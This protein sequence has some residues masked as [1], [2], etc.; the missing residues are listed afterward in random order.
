MYM[1]I[2]DDYAR[3]LAAAVQRRE[4]GDPEAS[5]GQHDL[6]GRAEGEDNRLQYCIRAHV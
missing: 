6:G 2:V 3:T 4:D 1:Y 5:V